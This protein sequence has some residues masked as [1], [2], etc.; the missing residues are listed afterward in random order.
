MSLNHLSSHT[1]L[2]LCNPDTLFAILPWNVQKR[3]GHA[4]LMESFWAST[5]WDQLALDAV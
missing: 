4:M 2:K 5:A 3:S 1:V